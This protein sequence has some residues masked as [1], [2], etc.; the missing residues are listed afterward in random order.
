MRKLTPKEVTS[1]HLL[2]IIQQTLA[3]T[4]FKSSS[5]QIPHFFSYRPILL[6]HDQ[7]ERQEDLGCFGKN[8]KLPNFVGAWSHVSSFSTQGPRQMASLSPQVIGPHHCDQMP[9]R[10]TSEEE[11]FILAHDFKAS[12]PSWCGGHDR[13]EKFAS[14]QLGSRESK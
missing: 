6:H 14:R 10:N 2:E 12:H 7:R 13:A 3:K 5:V 8:A 1:N 11:R 4:G 9:G